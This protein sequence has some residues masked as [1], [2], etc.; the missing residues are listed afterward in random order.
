MLLAVEEARKGLGRTSPNPAVGALVV[1]ENRVVG[2]GF[3]RR[4]GRPHAEVEALAEAAGAARG[5]ELYS[6]L[7]PCDHQ[8]RTPPCTQAILAAGIRRVIV[9]SDDPNPLVSGKGVRRLRS[10]GLDVVRGVAKAECDALNVEW[11]H[12]ITTGRPHVTLKVA[13]TADGKLAAGSGDSRWITGLAARRRVHRLRGEVDAVLVGAGT[14]RQDDPRLTARVAG[15]RSPLRVVLDGRL[16][17]PP[18]RRVFGQGLPGSLLVTAAG[19]ATAA[20]TARFSAKGVEIAA[21]PGRGGRLAPKRVLDL[22]G[23][24][25]VVRLLVEGGAEVHR[26]FIERSL[27]DRLL[28]FVA[29]KILGEHGVPWLRLPGG[30]RMSD[31]RGLGALEV[32]QVGED[33]LL[34]IERAPR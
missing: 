14:I 32:E 29:P 13:I 2:R 26:Q 28:L 31:A 4:A 7:E 3:H 16:S 6:T 30:Q 23:R 21:L 15:A 8:G 19:A 27:W 9:G 12:Y 33:A 5:A 17:V 20:R 34:R 25:G 11:F 22:L 10:A 18:D 24:R 1:R